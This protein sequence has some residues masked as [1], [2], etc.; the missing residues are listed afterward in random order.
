MNKLDLLCEVAWRVWIEIHGVFFG[1]SHLVNEFTIPAAK[2]E[3]GGL[4]RNEGPKVLPD[5][6]RPHL[7]AVLKIG[8]EAAGVDALQV[9]LVVG[10]HGR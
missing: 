6:H 3:D 8:R 9:A 7:S 2:I 5:Q 1:G 10:K 4:G